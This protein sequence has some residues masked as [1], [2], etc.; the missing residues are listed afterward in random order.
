MTSDL[1]L[2]KKSV[3]SCEGKD[4][5]H[6]IRAKTGNVPEI[7]ILPVNDCAPWIF[8]R[9]SGNPMISQYPRGRGTPAQRKRIPRS[10]YISPRTFRRF[11]K[12]FTANSTA[13]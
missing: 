13:S 6:N 2:H 11:E 8:S 7:K 3:H 5:T 9:F 4:G 1:A 12:I 10:R